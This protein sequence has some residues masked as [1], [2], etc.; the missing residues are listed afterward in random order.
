MFCKL[1]DFRG[2]VVIPSKFLK[3][4]HT[5]QYMDCFDKYCNIC[6]FLYILI[7]SD[8]Y[9]GTKVTNPIH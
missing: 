8:D 2:S 7:L 5:V 4:S 9:L 1:S 6:E 3:I